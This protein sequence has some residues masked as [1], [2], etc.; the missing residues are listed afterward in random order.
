MRTQFATG[1][2]AVILG[3]SMLLSLTLMPVLA[4]LLLPR[5]MD[6]GDP[7]VVRLARFVYDRHAQPVRRPANR[8]DAGPKLLVETDEVHGDRGRLG[9]RIRDEQAR[10]A[11]EQ[12]A[13]RLDV[14]RRDAF[15]AKAH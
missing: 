6:E 14:V 12:T 8:Y 15:A 4:A 5:R 3:G 1:S 11:R 7:W 10:V 13:K 9:G 2:W